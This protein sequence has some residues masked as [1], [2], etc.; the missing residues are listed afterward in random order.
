MKKASVARF[1]IGLLIMLLLFSIPAA[2]AVDP[3]TINTSANSLVKL[4]LMQGDQ[5]GNL[6]LQSK[7][8]RCEFVTMVIRMMGYSSDTAGV[9]LDFKDI[10]K[11]HWAYNY[12]KIAVKNKLINGYPDNTV[13]PD[14]FVDYTEAQAILIRALGYESTLTG[15][16]PDNV[17]NKSS[18]LSLNKNISLAKDKQLTRGEASVLIYNSLTIDFK[19]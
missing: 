18:E 1:S 15:D 7:V 6:K 5:T 3:A 4:K 11:K 8:T 9:N 12:I 10:S 13:R 17:L 2:A 14:N 19:K 16:W